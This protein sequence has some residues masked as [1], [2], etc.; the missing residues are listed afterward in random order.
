VVEREWDF[1]TEDDEDDDGVLIPSAD[2]DAFVCGECLIQSPMLLKWAGSTKARMV[3][4]TS[5]TGEWFVYAGGPV[6]PNVEEVVD[7]FL[8][9]EDAKTALGEKRTFDQ[10]EGVMMNDQPR[11]AE[12]PPAKKS[13][14][15]ASVCSAPKPD[16]PIQALLDKIK[17]A[18]GPYLEGEGYQG[19]GDIF[20]TLG[21]RDKWC[22]CKDVREP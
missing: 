15:E 5:S 1:A 21:W 4:R 14:T 20:F 7:P 18:K 10:M 19:S 8:T 17:A 13:R 22:R 6:L 12:E 11:N 9:G 2:Y 16:P 3:V